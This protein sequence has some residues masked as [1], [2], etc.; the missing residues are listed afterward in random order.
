MSRSLFTNT[1]QYYFSSI[2]RTHEGKKSRSLPAG[3]TLPA[4]EKYLRRVPKNLSQ[5][6]HASLWSQDSA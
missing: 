2:I 1:F 6:T 4:S 5:T 3:L